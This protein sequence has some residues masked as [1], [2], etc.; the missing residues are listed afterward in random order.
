MNQFALKS[1]SF[2]FFST[3]GLSKE[4]E[5]FSILE[6]WCMYIN[7]KQFYKMNQWSHVWSVINDDGKDDGLIVRLAQGF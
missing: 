2:Q 3:K 4:A 1:N 7:T 6:I 5:Q